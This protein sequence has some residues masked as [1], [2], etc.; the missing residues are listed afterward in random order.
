MNHNNRMSARYIAH[1]TRSLAGYAAS[2]FLQACPEL[3]AHLGPGASERW[4]QVFVQLLEELSVALFANRPEMFVEY[5]AWMGGLLRSRDLPDGGLESAMQT[6]C[7]V[8]KAELP[9]DTAAVAIDVC[10]ESLGGLKPSAAASDVP[11][12]A[13]TANGRLACGYLLALLEGDCDRATRLILDAAEAGTPV[14]ELYMNVLIP[15]QQEAGRMWHNA[16]INIAEEHFTTATTRSVMSRLAGYAVRKGPNGKTVLTSSVSGN[17]HDLGMQAVAEFF[18]MDGWR[19]IQLGADL[20]MHDLAQAVSFYQA[21]LVGLSVTLRSQIPLLAKTI[22]AIRGTG[23]GE[24]VKILVGGRA[25]LGN[26]DLPGTLGA[27]GYAPNPTEAVRIG[28]ALAGLT[29][30]DTPR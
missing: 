29:G 17:Q 25:F 16:E 3:A 7:A 9:A 6:L 10:R 18:G 22:E 15:A 5:A 8:L 12:S 23:R 26:T 19:V 28:N 30:E 1:A 21:D 27:D 20:P 14:A 2:E 4:R 24:T 11:L 13:D